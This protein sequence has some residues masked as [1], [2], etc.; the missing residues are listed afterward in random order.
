[1]MNRVRGFSFCLV[2]LFASYCAVTYAQQSGNSNATYQQLRG[3][4][5]GDDVITIK[6]LELRRD[7][8][9]FTFSQGSVAF[10]GKVNG[11]VTG[12]V[13][14]GEGHFHLKPTTAEERHNLKILNQSE[15]FDEDFDQVVLRFTDATAAELHK[16]STGDGPQDKEYAKGAQ[17]FH[18]FLRLKLKE[19]LDLRVLEDVLSPTPGALFE[20]AIHGK[21]NSHL[22][23]TADPHGARNVEPEEVSLQ[24]WSEWGTTYLAAFHQETDAAHGGGKG[25]ERNATFRIDSED[26]DVSIEKNGFLTGLATVHLTAEEDGVAVAPFELYPTLRVSRVET[27]KSEPLDFVQEKKEEDA[28]FGVV[29]AGPLKKGE[30]TTIRIAYGGKDVVKNEGGLTIIR[31]RARAGIPTAPAAWAIMPA[32]T[33]CFTCP[34]AWK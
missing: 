33:C 13:F 17:D 32:I 11:K 7:A 21:K 14:K 2:L 4:L 9:T 29:L 5:P 1:M 34:R 3:L 16:A 30:S 28:D 22:V 27:E 26:L 8:A 15:E 31:S 24:N 19:N 12:A 10:Y 23:F 6:N 25:D 18:S 20:A